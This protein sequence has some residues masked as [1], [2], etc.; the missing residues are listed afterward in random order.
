MLFR[1]RS[2]W[3]YLFKGYDTDNGKLP[4]LIYVATLVNLDEPYLFR[5]VLENFQ[6][7]SNGDLESI[8][9]STT[10]RR[11]LSQDRG[12]G[13]DGDNPSFYSI[14][15]DYFVLRYS[16]IVTLNGFYIFA[17]VSAPRA[18]TPGAADEQGKSD[19]D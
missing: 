13:C 14:D 11:K 9:L 3:Y 4:D 19:K 8:T 7:D 17:E 1:L 12:E 16:E 6:L 18:P 5:G 10:S 2:Q 15:G